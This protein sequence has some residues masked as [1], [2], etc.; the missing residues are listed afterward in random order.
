MKRKIYLDYAAS[1]PVAPAVLRAMMPYFSEEF[2][3]PSNLYALGL[4]ARK[5]VVE[6]TRKITNVLNCGS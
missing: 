4:R 3:N 1:T 6:A 2:G 5:A